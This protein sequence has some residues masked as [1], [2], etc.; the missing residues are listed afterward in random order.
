MRKLIEMNY[1][2]RST[3]LVAV[4]VPEELAKNEMTKVGVM[5]FLFGIPEKVDQNFDTVTDMILKC[6]RPILKSFEKLAKEKP[7]PTK[8]V[9]EFGLNF[10]GKGNIYLIETSLGGSI[11]VNFEWD[12][13][14][15][16]Q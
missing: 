15:D 11:K 16:S 9:V 14:A 7:A 10:N 5:D 13:N 4:D 2:D 8:A 1:D 12:L 3:I 6:S